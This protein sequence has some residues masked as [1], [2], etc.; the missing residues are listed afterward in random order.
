MKHR[1]LDM[2]VC[3]ECQVALKLESVEEES[4]QIRTCFLHCTEKGCK[5]PITNFVPRFVDTDK[6]VDSFSIQR[7]YTRRHFDWFKKDR[8]GY[9][10]FT[11]TTG[12]TKEDLKEGMTLEAG[13][14]YGR[15]L[16]VVE[17][18]GGE[19]VGFD[20]STP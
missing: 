19:V 10:L 20:L 15:F 7:Q 3:P 17:S 11:P 14:G 6:Y 12:F 8:Q 5:Y 9:A 2:L 18:M 4:G 1:L 13:C 16:D